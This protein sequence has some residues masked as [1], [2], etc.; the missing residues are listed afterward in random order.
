MLRTRLL[1]AAVL[2]PIAI[3][4]IQLG[5]LPFLGMVGLLLAVAEIEF[6]GLV[7]RIGFRTYRAL[8]IAVV[9]LFLL[10]AQFP[11]LL[12]LRPGLAVI[13]FSSLAWQMFRRHDRG[14]ADWSLAIASGAYLGVCGAALVGLRGLAPDGLWWTYSALAAIMCADS[15]AFF[16]GRAIGRHKLAP[17]LSPGK[18]WEGY[19]AGV[20]VGGLTTAL[21]ASLWPTAGGSSTVSASVYGL[22]LGLLISICAPLGDLAVSMIKREAGAKDTGSAIPGHGGAL[23]RVDSILW[24]AVIANYFVLWFVSGS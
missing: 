22:V 23:D 9:G 11:S 10:D 20:G 6:C 17:T 18:T 2:V 12:W 5:G 3:C 15:A 14:I 16:V 1:T 7:A 24:A 8:G 21:L 4:I 13:L 19:V